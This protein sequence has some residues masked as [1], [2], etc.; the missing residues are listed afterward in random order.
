MKKHTLVIFVVSSLL[1]IPA[2]A[3]W[4]DPKTDVVDCAKEA[5]K[6]VWQ[7]ELTYIQELVSKGVSYDTAAS[8]A[9]GLVIRF[10]KPFVVCLWQR[11]RG[12]AGT[13]GSAEAQARAAQYADKW[14]EENAK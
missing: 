3:F 12:D 5:G 2:C 4:P 1:V 8:Y 11:I 6:S 14:L 9:A 13:F 7:T 10:G